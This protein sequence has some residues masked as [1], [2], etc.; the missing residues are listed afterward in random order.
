[1][2]SLIRALL[3]VSVFVVAYLVLFAPA[4]LRRIG[5][6]AKRVG[7]AYVAAILI[8]AALR[9]WFGWGA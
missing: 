6:H 5:F 3:I 1:M 7:F 4:R 8:S 9:L 2:G